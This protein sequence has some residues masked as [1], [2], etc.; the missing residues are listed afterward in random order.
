MKQDKI[1]DHFQSHSE[2]ASF[3][4]NNSRLVYLAKTIFPSDKRV[5]NIGVGNGLL[6]ELLQ[7][8]GLDV[9]SLDPSEKAIVSLRNRLGLAE[10]SAKTG[11]SQSIPFGDGVFDVVFMSEVIEHLD[12]EVLDKTLAEVL[13]VLAPSGRYIGT[14]PADEDLE[15][16]EVVCPDCGKVFHR[17]GHV[18]SFTKHRLTYL[19]SRYFVDIK[20]ARAHF[21]SPDTLNWKGKL[22]W[23]AKKT[24]VSLGVNGSGENY[25]FVCHKK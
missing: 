6:E 15:E 8:R 3:K 2:A 16:N 18:Q 9:F 7:S 19:F 4:N 10:S 23:L 11:Y 1:W 22:S 5:L 25:Y 21:G 13:R 14:V 24:L 20:I 17:W 12:N